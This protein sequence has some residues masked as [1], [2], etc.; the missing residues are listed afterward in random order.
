MQESVG[1]LSLKERIGQM[2]IVGLE[3]TEI[4]ADITELIQTYKIG[5]VYI[6]EKNVYTVEKLQKLI[7]ELKSANMGNSVPLFIA[8]EQETGRGNVLPDEIRAIPA[9]K[10]IVENTDK[11]VVYDIANVTADILRKLGFNMNFAPLMDM[12]GMVNGVPLGDRCISE[13]NTTLVAGTAVQIV[14][15]HKNNGIIA[16]PRYFPGHS[17]TKAE[18][19]NL[20][21]PYTNKSISKLEHLDLAGFKYLIEEGIETMLVGHIHLSKLNMFTPSS[22]SYKVIDRLLKHK[23]NFNGITIAD[24]LASM[25]IAV[26]YGLKT[27]VHKAILAGNNMMIISNSRRVKIILEDLEKQIS[28]GNIDGKA[29][30]NRVQKILDLKAKYN[31]NDNEMPII[32]VDI[33]NERIEELIKRIRQIG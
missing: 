27:A 2:F 28:K 32:N 3:G 30:E 33:E 15:A 7:N 5:G 6:R 13:N 12:G 17:T 1:N 29:L 23:Y 20:V 21:I 25:P 22:L 8:T 24:D 16:V 4:D 10:Y 19:S 18:R 9:M 31:V 14:N 26:Q 11:S